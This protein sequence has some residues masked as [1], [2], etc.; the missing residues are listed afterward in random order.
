MCGLLGG[1]HARHLRAVL[2]LLLPGQGQWQWL[3][4]VACGFLVLEM[5]STSTA[6]GE[7]VQT[8]GNGA[9][10]SVPAAHGAVTPLDHVCRFCSETII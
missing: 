1:G 7:G 2:G 3:C 6:G 10:C 9:P 8:A 5:L 4:G